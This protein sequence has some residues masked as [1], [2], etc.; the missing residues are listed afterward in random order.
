MGTSTSNTNLLS[1]P[2]LPYMQ[3]LLTCSFCP[4]C[5]P[6]PLLAL[7]NSSLTTEI[8]LKISLLREACPDS[9]QWAEALL[10]SV[11]CKVQP[12]CRHFSPSSR[13]QLR[14]WAWEADS[15]WLRLASCVI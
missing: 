10:L 7:A 2:Q 9:R 4:A 6:P 15:A 11:L 12:L 5:P 1:S 8:Q 14:G 13:W 3:P